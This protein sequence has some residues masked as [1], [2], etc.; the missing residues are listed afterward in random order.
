MASASDSATRL[1]GTTETTAN[2]SVDTS[3]FGYNTITQEIANEFNFLITDL[4]NKLDQVMSEVSNANAISDAFNFDDVS[5]INI[6]Y[7]KLSNDVNKL[8]TSLTDLHTAFMKDLD[9]INDELA[10]NFGWIIIGDV[11][12]N[13]KER[14]VETTDKKS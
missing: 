2:Y 6:A 10:Y 4:P 14:T 11:K 1:D 3:G 8:K 9:N 12:G 5:D 13:T 7:T